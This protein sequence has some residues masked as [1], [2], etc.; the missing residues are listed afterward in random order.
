ML[1]CPNPLDIGM[2]LHVK[3]AIGPVIT[4]SSPAE[5]SYCA[6]TVI[7]SGTVS[8]SATATG[9]AGEV[10][11][12]SYEVGKIMSL[13]IHVNASIDLANVLYLTKDNSGAFA[14]LREILE[15][16]KC[17][18]EESS[19]KGLKVFLNLCTTCYQVANA[20]EAARHFKKAPHINSKQVKQFSYLAS[21]RPDAARSAQE[22][23]P[24]YE[25]LFLEE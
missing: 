19:A 7:V 23:D 14:Q 8:D 10:K 11:A 12:L 1:S 16:I 9:D 4:I 2:L 25:I 15:D 6:Q 13:D 20:N 18:G 22:Q 3:D 21:R 24:S 5:G 17:R